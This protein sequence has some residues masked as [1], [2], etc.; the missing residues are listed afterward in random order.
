MTEKQK[1]MALARKE[2]TERV[3]N[4]RATQEKFQRAREEY[5]AT[6]MEAA[7]SVNWNHDAGGRGSSPR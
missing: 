4:F 1:R 6:T 7:R 3:A 2:I 5:Y